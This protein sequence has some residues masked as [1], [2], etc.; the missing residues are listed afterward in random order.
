M[1]HDWIQA[2]YQW[3]QSADA[4]PPG[5]EIAAG[6]GAADIPTLEQLIEVIA[7]TV[8]TGP[9]AAARSRILLQLSAARLKDVLAEAAAEPVSLHIEPD[10]L[11]TLYSQLADDEPLAAAHALQMLA[12][13]QDEESMSALTASLDASPPGDWQATAVALSPLWNA[14]GEALEPFFAQLDD[15]ALHAA[16]LPVLLDLANHAVR[17]QKLSPHPWQSRGELFDKLLASTVVQ[18]RKLEKDPTQ[19]GDDINQI[20]KALH[21]GVALAIALCDTLG[22]V[23][24][25]N[26]ESLKSAMGLSHRRIQTEAACALTQ[27]GNAEGLDRMLALANDTVA[28]RRVVAYAEELGIAD[29]IDE[30]LR[31]PQALAESEL[32][33]WL[34]EPSQYGIP[35]T[36]LELIDTQTLYWPSYEEPQVCFLFRFWFDLPEGRISNA[37]IAGPLTHAF[38]ERIDQLETEDM[39]A[40]FAG[41]HCEHED[42]FEVPAAMLNTAQRREADAITTKLD[43]QDF[44]QIELQALTF[45]LGEIAVVA[46]AENEGVKKIVVADD[47]ELICL[48]VGQGPTAYTP[49][50]AL[51]IYRGRKLLR[52]FNP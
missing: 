1:N 46:L 21:D 20:Q 26:T 31:L 4:E 50:L 28:R 42:I 14:P 15:S 7:A 52:T 13:Q 10:I 38:Q 34:A 37:G 5:E 48:P 45:L 41:W 24:Y 36:G 11:A 22:Q 35:P 6:I 30:A 8:A 16:V 32:A 17:S 43:Q 47:S 29:K 51:A 18:L 39:F 19:F 27:L 2:A 40:A 25:S 3:L 23:G 33:S 12:A 49:T 9:R 44:T